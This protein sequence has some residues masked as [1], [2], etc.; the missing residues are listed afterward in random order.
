M[1]KQQRGADV[2]CVQKSKKPVEATSETRNLLFPTLL[3]VKVVIVTSRRD[4]AMQDRWHAFMM[5]L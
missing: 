1:T 5:L 2:A 3:L 4:H